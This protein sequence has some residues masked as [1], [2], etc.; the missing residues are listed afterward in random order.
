MLGRL[1]SYDE[2]CWRGKDV[3]CGPDKEAQHIILNAQHLSLWDLSSLNGIPL[4][5]A[6]LVGLGYSFGTPWSFLMMLLLH[7]QM[8]FCWSNLL[9]H[10]FCFFQ[11]KALSA[12]LGM[13][14][15]GHGTR[16]AIFSSNT[17][18]AGVHC[19][20]VARFRAPPLK[21]ESQNSVSAF[22][23]FT[24]PHLYFST[25]LETRLCFHMT[26]CCWDISVNPAIYSILCSQTSLVNWCELGLPCRWWLAT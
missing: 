14:H 24:F 20:L 5:P 8:V 1:P 9:P 11:A 7:R 21:T 22:S 26:Q 15:Y 18:A 25:R 6:S 17:A 3:I 19:F 13:A 23:S 4:H 12:L 10:R 2:V 16:Q